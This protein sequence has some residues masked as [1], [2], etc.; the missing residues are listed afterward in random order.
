M[1]KKIHFTLT[2]ESLEEIQTAIQKDKREKVRQR[3]LAIRQLHLGKK[4]EEVAEIMMVTAV[5]INGW[6]QRYQTKGL[7]GLANK[8]AKSYQRKIT[9]MY[10]KLLEESLEQEPEEYGYEQAIWTQESLRDHLEK[11]TGI[12]LSVKW[13][14]KLMKKAGYVYRRP[15]HDLGNKA[16]PV[17]KEKASEALEELKKR[18]LTVKSGSSLWTKQP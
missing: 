14:G 3:A 6:W 16:D 17:A 18:P 1:P 13:V 2:T 9:P 8:K 10:L 5:T 4:P 11:E 12:R 15:K 7:E